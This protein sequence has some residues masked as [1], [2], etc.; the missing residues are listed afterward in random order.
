MC[1]AVACSSSRGAVLAPHGG[2]G[3]LSSRSAVD[4]DSA[5]AALADSTR[6]TVIRELLRE[7]LRA[8]ELAARVQMSPPALSRHLRVLREAGL[9][10]EDGLE[11]D[12]RVSV[13]K[14]DVDAFAPV[15]NWLDEVEA[16][17]HEQLA[18]FKE[19]AEREHSLR[20]ASRGGAGGGGGGG[21][22]GGGGA[23]HGGSSS[24]SSGGRLRGSGRRRR[25]KS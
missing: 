15:R 9:I 10:V 16:H 19:F 7:P 5:F 13:Y 20:R 24:V 8:G 12:A 17:W 21:G 4:L 25:K 23:G 1:P 2:E 22:A 14:I 18:A 3:S 6:R 11:S